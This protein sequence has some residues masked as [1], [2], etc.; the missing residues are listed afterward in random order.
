MQDA[1]AA[2]DN[3]MAGVVV[4]AEKPDLA[5]GWLGES[6]VKPVGTRLEWSDP[7]DA[8]NVQDGWTTT[9]RYTFDTTSEGWAGEGATSVVRV[10]TPTHD[11]AGALQ[12]TKTMGA[13]FDSLRFNDAQGLRDISAL[14]RN[15]S[16][17]ALVPAGAGGT[18]WF[19]HIEVQDA[20]FAWIPAADV[21]MTPGTWSLLTFRDPGNL[22]ASMRSIGVQFSATGVS[23][24][25]T[26]VI[27]TVTQYADDLGPAVWNNTTTP[28]TML[29]VVGGAATIANNVIAQSRG[30]RLDVM[31]AAGNPYLVDWEVSTVVSANAVPA[32]APFAWLVRF[33]DASGVD[34]V[35]VFIRVELTT[36]KV[37]YNVFRTSAAGADTITPQ[38]YVDGV[39]YT[40]N[41]QLGVHVAGAGGNVY[42]SVWD[43][44]GT[45]PLDWTS[46]GKDIRASFTGRAELR[47]FL[48]TSNSNGTVTF[49]FHTFRLTDLRVAG[50]MRDR[51]GDQWKVSHSLDDGMPDAVSSSVSGDPYG[52]ATI[53]V[54]GPYD[55][56]ARRYYSRFNADSPVARYARDIATVELGQ[57]AQTAN[58]EETVRVFTGQMVNL[59]VSGRT[60][61]IQSLSRTRMKL[62]KAVSPPI[63]NGPLE[64]VEASWLVSYILWVCGVELMPSPD[65]DTTQLWIPGHGTMRS[66]IPYA[67]YTGTSY[68]K[69]HYIDGDVLATEQVFD[70]PEFIDGPY[71]RAVNSSLDRG[72]GYAYFPD[73]LPVRVKVG[74][75]GD[76]YLT[77]SG[78]RGRFEF[79]IKGNPKP[80]EVT[81]FYDQY[82]AWFELTNGAA[83]LV[84][85]F[86]DSNRGIKLE[87]DDG[88]GTN[89][90][91]D[92]GFALPDDGE[93]HSVGWSYDFAADTYSAYLDGLVH[94]ISGLGF[95]TTDLEVIDDG[96]RE[97]EFWSGYP[98]SDLILQTGQSTWYNPQVQ[99]AGA[100]VAFEDWEDT[101]Y[102]ITWSG[103]WARANDQAFA[104]TWSLKSG[105]AGNYGLT[106]FR[107]NVPALSNQ[108][109]FRLRLSTEL[110]ND[111]FE[112]LAPYLYDSGSRSVSNGWGTPDIGPAWTV[113]GTA[114]DYSA[115]GSA[116]T[117]SLGSANVERLAYV[118]TTS[119]DGDFAAD[120]SF[121]VA[122]ATGAPIRIR[123]RGRG[124]GADID[125]NLYAQLEL[126]TAGDVRL[127][128]NQRIGGVATAIVSNSLL[129]NNGAGST[130]RVKFEWWG[131]H[132]RATGFNI[133]TPTAP[134]TIRGKHTDTTLTGTRVYLTAVRV[135][136]NTVATTVTFDAVAVNGRPLYRASGVVNAWRETILN[137]PTGVTGLLFRY[138]KSQS[139]TGGSDAVWIDNMDFRTAGVI[140]ST[141]A[142]NAVARA[143]DVDIQSVVE[144]TAR[145]GWAWLS[146]L[147]QSSMTSMR[148]DELDRMMILPPSYFVESDQ[149]VVNDT[150]TTQFNAADPDV[151]LDP[152]KIRTVVQVDFTETWIDTTTVDLLR[153]TTL[154]EVPVGLSTYQLSLDTP[155]V[156]VT[157]FLTESGFTIGPPWTGPKNGSLYANTASNGEGSYL[158]PAQFQAEIIAWSSTEVTI[159]FRNW[160]SGTAYIVNN[161]E[162]T[163][164]LVI[165]GRGVHTQEAAVSLSDTQTSRKDRTLTVQA[166]SIQTRDN[167]RRLASAILWWVRRPR[168]EVA[169]T[170]FGDPRRQPGDLYELQ[171]PEGTKITGQ[172]RPL[173]IEHTRD[174]AA[175]TQVMQLKEVSP[176]AEWDDP[177]SGWDEGVWAP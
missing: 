89:T 17:W 32:G 112:V 71:Y 75:G 48:D 60:A 171:D 170:V 65:P 104:G 101:T 78:P 47:S 69:W 51:A 130:W 57:G 122:A 53:E 165:S 36:N 117:Q 49:S 6:P 23:G 33:I 64:G 138:S 9:P 103:G 150:I 156:L 28:V 92:M 154:I 54:V 147:C 2:F 136:G 91:L 129:G 81:S 97:P 149:L 70:P 133:T 83:A 84:L 172:W 63:A 56:D 166:P 137:I 158:G 107:V 18:G 4:W 157:T 144:R 102:N 5:V 162:D 106:S 131:Q 108:V 115:N 95:N 167:A 100:S 141:W 105:A 67:P 24:S 127:G 169:V 113:V 43:N 26:V 45:E 126:D 19:A 72:D 161:L 164:Y 68:A 90:V 59:P 10:T 11:G 86:I 173:A 109:A 123:I 34:F 3:A 134:V 139:G 177:T 27:D 140:T 50:D 99:A 110:N 142:P 35:D 175:Y 111:F 66:F 159:E 163:P 88:T 94:T 31:D 73:H 25:Q 61:E 135:L 148:V 77:Q 7:F 30:A 125:N 37:Y 160:S 55:M 145:E 128:I 62:T 12:A 98:W 155:A 87:L 42:V 174:E 176:V 152:T 8:R 151:T 96:L 21:S 132:V 13:G 153:Y 14:G 58:G 168:A 1:S 44:T 82:I 74:E 114:S 121:G 124:I 85:G 93:W 16:I 116:L 40:A 38:T 39:V 79:W 46:V 120:I 41:M 118:D 146:E 52:S 15:L 119:V 20:A 76:H 80:P 143:I 29:D 22:F